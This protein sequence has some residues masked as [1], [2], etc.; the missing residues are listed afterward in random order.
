MGRLFR[1]CDMERGAY[2]QKHAGA[3]RSTETHRRIHERGSAAFASTPEKEVKAQAQ[4]VME[5]AKKQS[6]S[7]RLED[8]VLKEMDLELN[9]GNDAEVPEELVFISEG[10]WIELEKRI[11]KHCAGI[12]CQ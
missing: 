9:G 10:A 7:K 8:M 2:G 6:Q 5:T 3:Q 4:R 1:E 12:C 11:D